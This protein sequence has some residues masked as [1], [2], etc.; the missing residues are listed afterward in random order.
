MLKWIG[1]ICLFLVSIFASAANAGIDAESGARFDNWSSDEDE[2][3]SQW[4]VPVRITGEYGP[5]AGF[6][7]GGYAY[8]SGDVDGDSRSIGGI[9]DTQ[10]G[11]AYTLRNLWG[12]D[13]QAGID[14]NLPTGQTGE[15][16]R[17]LRTMI[18]PDLVTIITPGRGFNVNPYLS[19]TRQWRAWT[20]GFGA[21]YAVQGQYDYSERIQDYNPGDIATLTTEIAYNLTHAWA[22]SVQAQYAAIGK[23]EVDGED[24]LQKGDAW[25]FGLGLRRRGTNLE[26]HLGVQAL[27]R[28]KARILQSDGGLETESRNSQGDEWIA[29]IETRHAWRPATTLIYSLRYLYRAENEYGRT[30]PFYAG[31][32][33]KV[34]LSLGII[35]R[36]TQELDLEC[37]LQGFSMSDDPNWLHPDEERTYRGWSLSAALMK[38]F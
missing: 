20:L 23:D 18:D 37:S 5:W 2:S 4:Y 9:L 22:V 13:W 25:L 29:E 36:L 1:P 34:S 31:D 28:D 16:D 21:G 10:T 11:A 14:L 7:T 38:R 26:T 30:S 27:F 12:A 35:Q 33:Q 17:D 3:G 8:T 24:V 32:R 6:V 15:D 19:M